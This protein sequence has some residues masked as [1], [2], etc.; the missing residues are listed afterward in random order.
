MHTGFVRLIPALQT[1]RQQRESGFG[2]VRLGRI[3]R[4]PP[5]NFVLH[6]VD[7]TQKLNGCAA[8]QEVL[9]VRNDEYVMLVGHH[10]DVDAIC[11]PIYVDRGRVVRRKKV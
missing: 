2:R 3:L 6:K 1:G 11:R 4:H 9:S 7:I 5:S 10:I 8:E